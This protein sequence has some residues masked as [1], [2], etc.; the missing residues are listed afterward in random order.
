MSGVC[1]IPVT[2]F[3]GFF[4][5][6]KTTAIKSLLARKPEQEKWAVLVNEFGE[7]AIDQMAVD[8]DDHSDVVIRDIRWLYVLYHERSHAVAVTDILRRVRPDRL[9][10][11]PTGIGHRRGYW[12]NYGPR[13]C[14]GHRG[15]R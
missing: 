13:H 8:P 10:I 3:T 11:E 5:V 1:K 2:L 6:G 9:L 14:S 7:V 15:A 12:M 4:G